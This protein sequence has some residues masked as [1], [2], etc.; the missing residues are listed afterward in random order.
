MDHDFSDSEQEIRK[1]REGLKRAGVKAT[2]QRLA[3][4]RE[5]VRSGDHPDAET[6]YRAVRRT[7][8]TV[9]LDTVYRTLR[10]LVDLGLVE[11]LSLPSPRTRFDANSRA[12]HH[13]YCLRCGAILDFQSEAFDRL[14]APETLKSLGKVSKIQVEVK[15][16]CAR[17]LKERSRKGGPR[18]NRPA[19]PAGRKAKTQREQPARF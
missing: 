17:C 16:L 2:H 7:L 4:F 13:F 6:L 9:S 3:I 8:P 10:L 14:A 18:S 15:G 12:H 5:I 19:F 11:A 1:L